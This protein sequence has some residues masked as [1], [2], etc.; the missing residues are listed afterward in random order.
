MVHTVIDG[1]C[2]RLSLHMRQE[3]HQTRASPGFCSMKQLGVLLLPPGWDASPCGVTQTALNPLEG[4]LGVKCLA[5]D[6][7]TMSPAKA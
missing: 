4:T 6:Y 1:L 5:P 7:T 2:L 3:A